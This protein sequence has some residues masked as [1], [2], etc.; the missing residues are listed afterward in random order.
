MK[1]AGI[2]FDMWTLF[3]PSFQKQLKVVFGYCD[4]F[5]TGNRE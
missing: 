4:Y 1:Y 2:P 3:A 5:I